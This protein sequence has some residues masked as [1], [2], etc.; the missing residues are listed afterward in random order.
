MRS[1]LTMRWSSTAR[2]RFL[3]RAAHS[4]ISGTRSVL[5]W[6]SGN[7][8]ESRLSDRAGGGRSS[9]LL[10]RDEGGTGSCPPR[11]WRRRPRLSRR[12]AGAKREAMAWRMAARPLAYR[13][14]WGVGPLAFGHFGPILVGLTSYPSRETLASNLQLC[15]VLKNNGW[16]QEGH[17]VKKHSSAS[18]A[19]PAHSRYLSRIGALLK[20]NDTDGAEATLEGWQT[21]CLGYLEAL[22]VIAEV[23]SSY[24]ECSGSCG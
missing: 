23:L 14:P 12:R 16:F 22:M 1:S 17:V 9:A 2:R 20:M 15:P 8:V 3:G 19:S 21:V 24:G 10:L 13:S 4:S 6:P 11:R 18:A 7:S 5:G